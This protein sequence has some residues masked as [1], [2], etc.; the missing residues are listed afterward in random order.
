MILDLAQ[1]ADGCKNSLT[2]DQRHCK[3]TPLVGVTLK[4][5]YLQ[6]LES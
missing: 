3:S 2:V 1:F 6:T 4:G 5:K